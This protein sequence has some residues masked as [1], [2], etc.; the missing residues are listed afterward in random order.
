MPDQNWDLKKAEELMD[1]ITRCHSLEDLHNLGLGIKLL[2]SKVLSD[3]RR[4]WL[5]DIYISRRDFLSQ[6]AP[7]LESLVNKKGLSWL[8]KN[9]SSAE[10]QQKKTT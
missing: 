9:A 6:E 2:S 7:P 10:D 8:K 1:A 3:E 5:R 4:A